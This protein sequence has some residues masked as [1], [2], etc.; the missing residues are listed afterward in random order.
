MPRHPEQVD[1]TP[2][3]SFDNE[4]AVQVLLESGAVVR[5]CLARHT[6]GPVFERLKLGMPYVGVLI[7]LYEIGYL[8]VIHAHSIILICST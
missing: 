3:V 5:L 6:A 8:Y 2:L 4:R 1:D 7:H